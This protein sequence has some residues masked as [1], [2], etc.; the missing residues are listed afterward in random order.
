MAWCSAL[1]EEE[2]IT[3]K[4]R[5]FTIETKRVPGSTARVNIRGSTVTIK[6]P[7]YMSR[8]NAEKTYS[9]FRDWAIRRLE[10]IDHTQLDP[11]PRYIEFQDGQA[12]EV[13]G[14]QF[15]IRMRRE[16]MRSTAMTTPEGTIVVR[17]ASN[18]SEEEGKKKAYFL[19]R[20]EITRQVEEDLRLHVRGINGRHFDF[21]LNEV[22]VRDQSTRWGSC[23][24]STGNITLNFRLLLA[25]DEV[26]DYVIVH[27][28]AH[29]KHANHSK[30][31]WS[32]VESVVPDYK[33]RRRWL[34]RN[35]NRIGLQ[36]NPAAILIG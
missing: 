3:V 8:P 32:L 33:E 24:R 17:T 7:F 27:E 20:R 31:F 28:L 26:R 18:L 29:L 19:V 14:H 13:M 11:K 9:S 12:L 5:E 22:L 34:N 36:E 6:L 25:P 35:G 2:R 10:R 1:H 16:G 23:S 15:V 4:G 21:E 30:R